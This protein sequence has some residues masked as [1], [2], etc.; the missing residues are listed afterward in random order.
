MNAL[1][2]IMKSNWKRKSRYPYSYACCVIVASETLLK[3]GGR[4]QNI[5]AVMWKVHSI[6]YLIIFVCMQM[7]P[8]AI[9]ECLNSVHTYN[10]ALTIPQHVHDCHKKCSHQTLPLSIIF[11]GLASE[12]ST[13]ECGECQGHIRAAA[14]TSLL[15]VTSWPCPLY[16]IEECDATAL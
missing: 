5:A 2:L 13:E 12:T 1:H 9:S 11:G 8:A 16:V 14:L 4:I 7:L 3:N 15:H 10:H 6:K